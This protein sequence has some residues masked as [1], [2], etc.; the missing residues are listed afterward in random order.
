MPEPPTHYLTYTY[1]ARASTSPRSIDFCVIWGCISSIS[2]SQL[3]AIAERSETQ[4]REVA[5]GSKRTERQGAPSRWSK[6]RGRQ[7]REVLLDKSVACEL[8]GPNIRRAKLGTGRRGAPSVKLRAK[9]ETGARGAPSDRRGFGAKP[10]GP[11]RRLKMAR[12]QR[13]IVE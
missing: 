12:N 7:D 5:V 11:V 8:C 13:G 2:S 10:P 6:R 1:S 9:R 3:R 4:E